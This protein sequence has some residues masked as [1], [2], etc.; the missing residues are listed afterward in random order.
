MNIVVAEGNHDEDLT[1]T[2]T[3]TVNRH[4]RLITD[5]MQSCREVVVSMA[6]PIVYTVDRSD[7][8]ASGGVVVEVEFNV[9]LIAEC[10]HTYL[11]LVWSNSESA[12]D[13]D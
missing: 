9:T 5:F 8:G 11:Y 3:G 12:N 13:V 6:G 10:H 1:D 7:D 4:E 2:G